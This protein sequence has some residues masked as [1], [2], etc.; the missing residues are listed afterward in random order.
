MALAMARPWKHPKTGIYWLR[1][2]VPE[3]LRAAVGKVEEKFSLKTRDPAEAKRLHAAALVALEER[4]TRL[5]EP[6]RKLDI[7]E[8]ANI[9]E[10]AFQRCV[11]QDSI[12][13]INWDS[14]VGERLWDD[15]SNIP[16]GE[17]PMAFFC[18]P[19]EIQ[20]L[21]Q[22]NWCRAVAQEYIAYKGLRAD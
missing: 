19:E 11:A 6:Q 4:W 18:R 5:R 7:S 9:S 13:G 16:K 15:N 2:H 21:M 8:F 12:P 14:E 10:E 3:E 1:K 20:R 22:E 17:D